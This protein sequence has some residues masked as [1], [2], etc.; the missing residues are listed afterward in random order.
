MNNLFPNNIPQLMQILEDW[1]YSR[2]KGEKMPLE[3]FTNQCPEYSDQIRRCIT[4]LED[5]DWLMDPVPISRYANSDDANSSL[6]NNFEQEY[7]ACCKEFGYH[8]I[9]PIGYGGSG[10]IWKAEGLGGMP[11]AIKII[12]LD[13]KL[14]I[15]EIRAL[16]L[17]KTI[18]HPHLLSI[19]GF[20][21]KNN[22]L[23]IASELA[24]K[25]LYEIHQSY[26]DRG[27]TGIPFPLLIRYF[28]EAAEAI[29]FLNLEKHR[30]VSG[31]DSFVQHGDIKLHNL[32]MAGNSI[33]LGD[34]GLARC[35]G[36]ETN[37]HSGYFTTAYAPPEYF[38]GKTYPASDQ[39]SLAVSYVR[40][41]GGVFPFNDRPSEALASARFRSPNLSN[42]S[43]PERPHL[44]KALAHNPRE[45][46]PDCKSFVRALKHCTT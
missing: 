45:R 13:N 27:D 38:E 10:Q 9:E 32:L 30:L 8:L 46:W 1:E 29:D 11:V 21:F 40:L 20:W 31:L 7:N 44:E 22:K 33:K 36:L 39:Y 41:R 37:N 17:F 19:F 2:L 23:W 12:S 16:D 28:S 25:N 35:I 42:I 24:D 26:L 5:M 4:M 34:F 18:R 14:S 3:Y 15:K 43:D 6:N